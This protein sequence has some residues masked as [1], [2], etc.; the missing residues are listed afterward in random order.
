[1]YIVSILWLLAWPVMIG[2]SYLL[3][4]FTLKKLKTQI[5]SE[6]DTFIPDK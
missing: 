3:V 4:I 6:N 5:E 2:I 1:M